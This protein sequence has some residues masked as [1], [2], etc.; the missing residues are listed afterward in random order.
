MKRLL[1]TL[2]SNE[3][4]GMRLQVSPVLASQL[5]TTL[6][7]IP[8][9]LRGRGWIASSLHK[10]ASLQ[11][12]GEWSFRMRRGH[13]MVGPPTSCL[14][15]NAAFTGRYDDAEIELLAALAQRPSFILDVGAS[16]GFY[17]IPL[18]VAMRDF[19]CHTIAFEPISRNLE[20]LRRNIGLNGLHADISVFSFALGSESSCAT[21]TVETGGAGNA[22][23]GDPREDCRPRSKVDM[24]RLDDVELP[25]NCRNLRCSVLKMDVE[26]FEMD[27]LKGASGFL[28]KHRPVIFG[29]F[30]RGWFEMRGLD[31]RAPSEWSDHNDYLVYEC[32][33]GRRNS[34]SDRRDLSLKRLDRGDTRTEDSLLLI[35]PEKRSRLEGL[36]T[37]VEFSAP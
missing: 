17:S 16:F 28:R 7:A 13:I 33:Y 31:A 8:I 21:A 30:S 22:A 29:E 18:A 34:L 4:S 37:C 35:P 3:E 6:R 32:V 12:W 23:I 19:G 36:E 11:N 14:T 9:D 20:I 24:L 15:W 2:R 5:A 26:G 25:E 1:T 27:V 10:R